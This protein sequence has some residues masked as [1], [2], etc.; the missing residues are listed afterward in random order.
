MN[1]SSAMG[2]LLM[3]DFKSS[4]VDLVDPRDSN[5]VDVIY[6]RELV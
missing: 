2:N 6:T 1:S 4:V 3:K 5:E